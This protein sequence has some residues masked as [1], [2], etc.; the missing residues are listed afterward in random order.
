MEGAR[1]KC[2]T[3]VNLLEFAS[4]NKILS[5]IILSYIRCNLNLTRKKIKVK[6]RS[7]FLGV[8]YQVF[9]LNSNT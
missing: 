9:Q 8:V 2:N 3:I 4:N 1:K 6:F 5:D 7:S